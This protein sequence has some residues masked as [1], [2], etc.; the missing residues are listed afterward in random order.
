[1]SK[2]KKNIK[3][4]FAIVI[5]FVISTLSFIPNNYAEDVSTKETQN[6]EEITKDFF[7][8]YS[9]HVQD[10]GW[11]ANLS[12]T[13]GQ[14][15]GTTGKN[16]KVEAVK[17]QLKDAPE[18][19]GITY[20]SYINGI[21]WQAWKKDGDISGTTGQN[22]R[23]EGIRIKLTGTEDYYVEY[24]THVQDIGWMSWKKDGELSGVIEKGLKI[25]A[26]EIRIISKQMTVVYQ[27]HVQDIGWQQYFNDGET[28]GVTGKNLKIEAMKIEL[29]NT[30]GIINIKYQSHVQDIGWEK[31]WKQNGEMTGTTG[32]NKKIEAIR[33]MLDETYEID[34][35]SVMYRAYVQGSGWQ[36]WKKDGEIAGTTGQNKRLEA[37]EIK[38][39]E[40]EPSNVFSVRYSS[41]V[42]DVGWMG[43][44]NQGETSGVVDKNLK[45]EAIKIIGKNIPEGVSIKY[46]SHVQDIG[47]EKEWIESGKQTGTTGKNL[48]VEAIKIKLE[49]TNEYSIAYRTYINGKG[50]QEWANDGETSGTTGQNRKIEAIEIKIVPKISNRIKMC[51]DTVVPQAIDKGKL[52]I[53]GWLMT[54]IEDTKIQVKVNEQ[55]VQTEIVRR[56][57]ADVLD[58]VKGYGGQEKNPAPGFK[59]TLDF[60]NSET[61]S[62][63]IKIQCTNGMGNKLLAESQ[64]NTKVYPPIKYSSGT[65]GA[66]GLKVAGR[67]GSDLPYL[68]YGNGENVFFATFALHGYEDL[69]DKDGQV[70][71]NFA[72]NF[73]K[74]LI[75]SKDYELAQKWTIYIF[76]GVNQDGLKSGW[77]NNGPGRTTLYSQAPNNKGIDLNRCWQVG[78]TYQKYTSSR[79]YNGTQGFQA[80]EA[81]ALRDFML[82]NKSKNG[83]TIVVD[84]HGWTQQ[85]IG[86]AGIC[87]YY[88]KQFPENDKSSV[89]RYGTGYMI[90]WARTYLGSSSKAARTALIELPNQGV[91][92]NQS[93]INYN[94]ENRYINATKEMLKSII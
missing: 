2:M 20:Q 40:Q 60:T 28:A 16:K 13:N 63:N 48:K 32:K 39:V 91:T 51:I 45:I 65:Y 33:I 22:R 57:R 61:E 7:V 49:G 74:N 3:K 71:V 64:I 21:G 76:P 31:S 79:N 92:G 19:I 6:S 46:K 62:K 52:Q 75:N 88:E 72:N 12:K 55:L 24:R 53:S 90:N 58:V 73:Y 50:W 9:S 36:D 23:L 81:Q 5:L 87:S 69:W 8:R 70:L 67:G 35:Y 18:N 80:Y 47:W 89:G 66:S 44:K 94:F 68:K 14:Q 59:F 15:S 83:Q 26:I 10:Y 86:D 17:I 77:T 43:Y 84:L 34:K 38:V 54:D 4:V 27:S 29:K 1:M 85:L 93:V 37:I 30:T 78:N 25:E 41:H 11:E 56:D 42:Q 82:A